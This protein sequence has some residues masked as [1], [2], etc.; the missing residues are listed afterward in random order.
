MQKLPLAIT[1]VG[2]MAK[3]A[4][5]GGGVQYIF[6]AV[7][8]KRFFFL[9]GGPN[10]LFGDIQFKMFGHF[11]RFVISTPYFQSKNTDSLRF[12]LQKLVHDMTKTFDKNCSGMHIEQ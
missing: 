10:F 12:F 8:K 2:I 3:M 1:Y 5:M 9:G 7:K 6:F 4:I 11:Y